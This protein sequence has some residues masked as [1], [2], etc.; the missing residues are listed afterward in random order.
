MFALE[1]DEI[2]SRVSAKA[3]SSKGSK[4]SNSS[5]I[6]AKAVAEAAKR[7]V[8][9]EYANIETQKK[10]ELKIKECE[11]EEM[12]KKKFYEQAEAEATALAKMEDEQE[13]KRLVPEILIDIRSE[14]DKEESVREYLLTLPLTPQNPENTVTTSV[15]AATFTVAPTRL[16][17]EHL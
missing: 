7:K 6:R 17:M 11:I 1:R 5:E 12:Q 9:W 3:T 2:T 13:E 8:D 14:I 15:S 16:S 4:R 10:V